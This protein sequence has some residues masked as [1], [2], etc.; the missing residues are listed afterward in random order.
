MARR[1]LLDVPGDEP[2]PA[3]RP[4]NLRVV[5]ESQFQ[6]A[7]GKRDRTDAAGEVV[8]V[9]TMLQAEETVSV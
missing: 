6:G 7:P 2:R 3:E 1:R 5:V 8:D 9:R 4:R